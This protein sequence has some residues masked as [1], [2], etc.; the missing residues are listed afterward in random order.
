MHQTVGPGGNTLVH[1][2]GRP[3]VVPRRPPVVPGRPPVVLGGG[4]GG[5][6]C[7]SGRR[8]CSV[9]VVLQVYLNMR[10]H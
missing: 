2:G 8:C 1:V 6:G 10:L 4:G 3:P 5:G 7:H 9:E